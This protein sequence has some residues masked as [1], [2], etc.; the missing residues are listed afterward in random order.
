MT[1]LDYPLNPTF[2]NCT[3]HG[4]TNVLDQEAGGTW[5]F[6]DNI[7]D[8]TGI[9]TNV[10]GFNHDYNGYTTN[11]ARLL[12][13]GAHDVVLSTTTVGYQSS[14]LGNYYLPTNSPFIDKGSLTNAAQIGLYHYTTLTNQTVEATNKL[15]IG[16][17]VVAT[18]ANGNPLDADGDGWPDYFED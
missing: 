3:F 13:Y 15:D 9:F 2:R 8:Q 18:D 11:S 1:G 5:T 7:F 12:P 16:F 6:K 4:G 14:W 10:T 17:H